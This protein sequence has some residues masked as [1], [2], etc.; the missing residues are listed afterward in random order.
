MAHTIFSA[1]ATVTGLILGSFFNVLIWRLPR[2]LSIISPPSHCPSCNRQIRPWENIPLI[3]YALLRGRC[4]GC[5][6]RISPRYPLIEALTGVGALLVWLFMLQPAVLSHATAWEL[7]ALSV[8]AATLLL[9]IP[10][11]VIDLDHL[12]LPDALTLPGIMIGLAVSFLPGG[13]TPLWSV[14]GL[15]AGGGV[16]YL[17]GWLGEVIFRKG[18]GMGGG[19]IKL[20]AWAGVLWGWQSVLLAIMLASLAG[21]VAGGVLFVTRLM[22]RDHRIPFG[23]F[24]AV[25]MWLAALVGTPLVQ[26]Y[27][28][29]TGPLL[30]P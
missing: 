1:I 22:P 26:W 14:V 20:M 25:G 2:R 9:L 24:L 4:A 17:F 5:R 16:L 21:A 15:L 10:L 27:M 19:D 7:A 30:L 12:I 28:Q 13:I 29:F 8:R 6:G 3:S 18:E 23:P 11:S